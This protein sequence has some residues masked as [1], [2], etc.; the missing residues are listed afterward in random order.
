MDI[1]LNKGEIKMN[2][3]CKILGIMAI[4]LCMM[5]LSVKAYTNDDVITYITSKHTVNGRTMQLEAD[6][7]ESLRQYLKQNPV[8]DT[9]AGDIIAKLDRAKSIISDTGATS[10]SQISDSV[11]GQLMFL[12]KDAGKIAGL[13]VE[14]DTVNN[15]ITIKDS[16][17]NVIIRPTSY[18]ILFSNPAA[19]TGESTT[20]KKSSTNK[21]VY[22][23]NHYGISKQM[24]LAI[25]VVAMSGL[26]VKKYAK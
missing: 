13:L 21:L 4:I 26:L 7:R 5:T 1:V 16:K 15:I 23:G 12:V 2:K 3:V 8:T 18:N 22:T 25:V 24:I 19:S 17:G 10:L 14:I 9:Q 11:K 6:Q 20:T